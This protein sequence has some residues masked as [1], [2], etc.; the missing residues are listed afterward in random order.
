MKRITMFIAALLWAAPLWGL[1]ISVPAESPE[2]SLVIFT[3]DTPQAATK[4]AVL[5]PRGEEA[6]FYAGNGGAFTGPPGRYTVLLQATVDGE[7]VKDWAFTAILEGDDSPDPPQPDPPKPDPPGPDPPDP[8]DPPV[9]PGKRLV[10]IVEETQVEEG[11]GRTAEQA[12]AFNSPQ[13]RTFLKSGSHLLLML[14]E[15]QTVPPEL[16]R[17]QVIARKHSLPVM[18]VLDD[19]DSFVGEPV[20]LP[21]KVTADDLI[22]LLKA[23]GG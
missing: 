3:C 22:K 14:D 10:V 2:H 13:W 8:P 20:E 18:F 19:Q 1:S 23:K 7:T 12:A 11:N 5:G 4:W 9:P 6:I 15:D 21:G 17:F 16:A